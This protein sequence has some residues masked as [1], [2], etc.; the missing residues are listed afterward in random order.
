MSTLT[1]NSILPQWIQALVL[2]L[3]LHINTALILYTVSMRHRIHN[4][5]NVGETGTEMGIDLA[6][7]IHPWQSLKW[8]NKSWNFKKV[9]PL[10]WTPLP[11]LPM[12]LDSA[13]FSWLFIAMEGLFK[14]SGGGLFAP[15]LCCCCCW[16]RPPLFVDE[17]PAEAGGC[18]TTVVWPPPLYG[19]NP[20]RNLTKK[21]S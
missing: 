19:Q 8:T 15:N 10:P 13:L 14:T 20:L 7:L 12:L 18:G 16:I 6:S 21:L 11:L 1:L 5:Y 9:L 4:V 17:P 3:L 2:E